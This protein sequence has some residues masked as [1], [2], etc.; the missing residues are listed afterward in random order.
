MEI[1]KKISNA[2]RVFEPI[3]ND[4]TKV[5]RITYKLS[6]TQKI[7]KSIPR[8]KKYAINSK[9]FINHLY[10]LPNLR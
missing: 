2:P 7:R 3:N 5:C 4:I 8:R 1:V 9:N 10:S 6:I